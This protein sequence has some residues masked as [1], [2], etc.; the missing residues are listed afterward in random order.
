MIEEN[1]A[2]TT[3]LEEEKKELEAKLS[4]MDQLESDKIELEEQLE[5]AKAKQKKYKDKYVAF[6]KEHGEVPT[7][8]D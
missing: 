3:K 2:N 8:K 7:D 4:A 5:L 6:K 1:S